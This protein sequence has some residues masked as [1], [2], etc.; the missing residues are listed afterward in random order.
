MRSSLTCLRSEELRW[1]RSSGGCLVKFTAAACLTLMPMP[2]PA[3][4]GNPGFMAPDTRIEEGG[5]PA[6]DQTN[7]TDVLFVRLV[8]E[9][10]LAE[11]SFAEL[12]SE[13]AAA[14]SVKEFAE[15]MVADHSAA[16]DK[17]TAIA[18]E[19]GLAVP[20]ELN[21]E[22]AALRENLDSLDGAAFDLTY[23]R[24][25]VVEHQKTAQLLEWEINSGQHAPLQRLA[26]ETLPKVLEHLAMARGVVE[27]LAREQ[28][29]ATLPKA[30]GQ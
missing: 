14:P 20:V 7:T 17:L 29:A 30:R 4:M 27:E 25:Q 2:A 19:S 5:M 24:T 15:K 8:A 12:A 18:G 26:A 10:G 1:R 21:A 22:H 11:V 6:T 16:N 23:M 3:Q 13:V 28:I 9:G